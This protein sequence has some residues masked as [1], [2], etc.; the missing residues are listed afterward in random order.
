MLE[1]LGLRVFGEDFVD[2]DACREPAALRIHT[3]F[4]QDGLA[5]PAIGRPPPLLSGRRAACCARGRS[6]TIG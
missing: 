1:N 2:L 5:D 4:V 3:F 6:R